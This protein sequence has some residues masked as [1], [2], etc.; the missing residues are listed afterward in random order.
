MLGSFIDTTNCA[1]GAIYANSE[2]ECIRLLQECE[3]LRVENERLKE[4]LVNDRISALEKQVNELHEQV[5]RLSC[6][7]NG[8]T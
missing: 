8:A 2:I 4:K 3:C 7:V 6:K 5:E 1:S